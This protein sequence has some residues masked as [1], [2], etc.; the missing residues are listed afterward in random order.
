MSKRRK[1]SVTAEAQPYDGASLHL[2]F[3]SPFYRSFLEQNPHFS[4]FF[5]S[6]LV[7]FLMYLSLFYVLTIVKQQTMFYKIIDFCFSAQFSFVFA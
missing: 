1:D 7:C 3:F 2:P 6:V 4:L 5:S